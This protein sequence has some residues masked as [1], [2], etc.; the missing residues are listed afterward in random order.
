MQTILFCH[1]LESGP[2]GSKY[3]ALKAAGYK[4]LAPDCSPYR[5]LQERVAVIAP[6]LAYKPLVIGSSFGG[7]AAVVSAI[8]RLPDGTSLATKEDLPGLVLCAPALN[9]APWVE[10]YPLP[11]P[12]T[13][14]H[15][16]RDE[17]V[18]IAVSRS[19]AA[20]TGAKLIEVDD[21]HRLHESE[22]I[23]LEAVRQVYKQAK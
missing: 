14:I 20:K 23:I 7:V 6:M 22:D 21:G 10:D 11:F 17:V 1:G 12:V 8:R 3:R 4:V 13:I 19:Y 18:P 9:L 2:N 16:V 15:G 5:T